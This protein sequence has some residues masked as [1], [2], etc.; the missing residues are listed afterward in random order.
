MSRTIRRL[1]EYLHYNPYER[2]H[3]WSTDM[4]RVPRHLNAQKAEARAIDELRENGFHPTSR[5]AARSNPGSGKIPDDHDD[6]NISANKQRVDK[7]ARMNGR[8][9]HW[10][11]RKRNSA[12]RAGRTKTE[13][14]AEARLRATIDRRCARQVVS[15]RVEPQLKV[16]R[17]WIAGEPFVG[18]HRGVRTP[19]EPG[20]IQPRRI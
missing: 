4:H 20:Y 12:K 14:R 16:K 3:Y 9:R 17:V 7:E 10:Y 15:R 2:E 11:P 13:R 8:P 5:V 6:L 19:N 1:P 18:K